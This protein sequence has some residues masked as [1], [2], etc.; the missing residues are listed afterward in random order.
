MTGANGKIKSYYLLLSFYK[1]TKSML[2][3]GV[4]VC[5]YACGVCKHWTLTLETAVFRFQPTVNKCDHLVTKRIID[6]TTQL[7]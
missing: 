4:D 6:V 5:M 7:P 1:A 2:A 3:G